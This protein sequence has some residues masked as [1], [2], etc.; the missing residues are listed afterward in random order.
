MG[1]D[2]GAVSPVLGGAG[3]GCERSVKM[4]LTDEQRKLAEGYIPLARKIAREFFYSGME[5]DEVL[6][7]AMLGLTEAAGTYDSAKGRFAA[8]AYPHVRNRILASLKKHR[9]AR[10]RTVYMDGKI[11]PDNGKGPCTLADFLPYHEKGFDRAEQYDLIPSLIENSTLS[12]KQAEAIM[13]V[14]VQ[15]VRQE[16]TSRMI[17]ITQS[18][19]SGR[20]ARGL[21]KMRAA[22]FGKEGVRR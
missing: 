8:W 12:K 13:L 10:N 22:Y 17:G 21:S 18:N 19:I 5:Y 11:F 1:S 14:I 9:A 16:D 7:Q 3:E 15:G 20:V 6:G 4:K 2:P